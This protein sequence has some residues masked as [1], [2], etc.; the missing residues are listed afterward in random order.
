MNPFYNFGI[1]AYAWGARLLAL[2]RRKVKTML[3]G[4]KLTFERLE[5]LLDPSRPCVWIHTSS[6]GEFEQG[7]PLIEMIRRELPNKQ[8]LL[9]FFSPSGFEVRKNYDKVDAVVYLPFD[10]P[11]NAA[12]FIRLAHPEIAIFVKYE[13]WGNYLSELKRLGIPTYI[14]S[15]IFRPGQIFFLPWGGMFR[16]ILRCFTHLFVQDNASLNLLSKIGIENVTVAGDTRFDRVTDILA[17]IKPMPA[18]EALAASSAITVVAGSTWHADEQF[19]LPYFNHHDDIKLIIAPHEVTEERLHQIEQNISRKCVRL[20]AA[21]LQQ[22]TEAD[23]LIVDC[24]G[25]LSGIYHFGDVAY[26]GG[27]FGAGIHNINEAAVHSLPIVFGPNHQKFKEASDLI[28]LGG[29]FSFSSSNDFISIFDRLITDSS[30]R[31]IAGEAAGKYIRE[32][33]GA[34]RRIFDAIFHQS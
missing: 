6:L 1:R 34:T 30:Y 33:I 19:I 13:F 26:V 8:I 31:R 23:C 14:I 18:A 3:N 2:H 27:G 16:K 28:A 9:S 4:Q 17:D 25:M 5:R 15:S 10:L 11:K 22:V 24:Y 20:S 29:A 32:N 21:T 12:Q 7:R